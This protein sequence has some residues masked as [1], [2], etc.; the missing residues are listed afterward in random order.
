MEMVLHKGDITKLDVDAVVNAANKSLLGGGGVDGAIHDAAGPE[1]LKETRKLGGCEP[2][3]A[4]M[5]GGY[6]MPVKY[7]IHTVGPVW[8]GGKHHEAEI[9]RDCY[10]NSLHL[11]DQNGVKTI[12]F[13]AISTGA[14]N[15]PKEEAARIAVGTVSKY[16]RSSKIQR[17]IFAITDPENAQIYEDLIASHKQEV[18]TGDSN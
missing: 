11:A 10:L 4:K 5:T 12:A 15:Y 2:G 1:L 18:V 17:V 9:L 8:R 7:I 3:E 6:Q 13:P 16:L 14:Y